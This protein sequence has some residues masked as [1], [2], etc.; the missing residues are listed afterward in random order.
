MIRR[1]LEWNSTYTY[2]CVPDAMMEK[3]VPFR[4]F[5]IFSEEGELVDY[6]SPK[7]LAE[8]ESKFNPF[9]IKGG[10]TACRF[11]VTVE[12]LIAMKAYFEENG[13]VN[14]KDGNDGFGI[15]IKDIDWDNVPSNGYLIAMVGDMANVPRRENEIIER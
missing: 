14:I 1:E 4:K 12:E 7:S 13:L 2:F 11:P 3:E 10:L 5:G 9:Q 15:D 8:A 6:N